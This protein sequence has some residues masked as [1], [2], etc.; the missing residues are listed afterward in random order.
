MAATALTTRDRAQG[1]AGR[2]RP[3]S[4]KRRENEDALRSIADFLGAFMWQADAASLEILFM[5]NGVKDLTGREASVW[6][7]PLDRWTRLIDAEDRDGVAECLHA[8]AADG[9]DRQVEFRVQG[10]DGRTVWLRHQVRLIP[11]R[12]GAHELW[13]VTTDITADKIAEA[14]A[15]RSDERYQALKAQTVDLR[16]QALE[17]ALTGLPNRVLFD[18]RLEAALRTAER[19]R[20]PVSVL[21]LD[22]DRFKEINDTKGHQ[23]G[24]VVLKHVALRL[25]IAMRAQDTPARVGGDE[26]ACLLPNTDAEGAVRA[27]QRIVRAF[28]DPIEIGGATFSVG[29]SIGIAVYPSNGEDAAGIL[30]HADAAMYQAKTDG[31]GYALGWTAADAARRV[32]ARARRRRERRRTAASRRAMQMM[33]GVAAI[34]FLVAG[35]MVPVARQFASEDSADR[36]DAAVV[37]LAH[38]PQEEVESIVDSVEEALV[39]ISWK[40]VS[41]AQITMTLDRLERLLTGLSSYVS[42]PLGRR[43]DKLLATIEKARTVAAAASGRPERVRGAG[44]MSTPFPTETAGGPAPLPTS[45]AGVIPKLPASAGSAK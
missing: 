32:G 23:A 39:D 9:H 30:G 6:V 8:V 40:D 11:D 34:L 26:F 18:D 21:M 38:A 15:R 19:S 7:G 12:S 10:A 37:E 25:R 22:L 44:Q 17:D 20:Q 13:G 29:V 4:A 36:L 31:G 3:R 42:T 2:R 41:Q 35:A 28:E 5:T 24:D 43:V 27:A 45:T 1:S 16:K 33:I 14:E